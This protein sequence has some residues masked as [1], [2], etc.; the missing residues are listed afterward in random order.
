MAAEDKPRLELARSVLP[1]PLLAAL[2]HI[3]AQNLSGCMLVGGTALAGF[4]AG[5]RRSDD[6]DLFTDGSDSQ[7]AVVLAVES[8]RDL[9][10]EL[11][12]QQRS[13]QF[14][15][16][17]CRFRGAVFT[18]DAARHQSLFK[19][20]AAVRLENGITV[21]SLRTLL[22]MKAA[23]LLSRCGEKDLYDL[24]WIFGRFRDLRLEDMVSAGAGVDAGSTP[25]GLLIALAGARPEEKSC[26]FALDPKI[27]ARQVYDDVVRLRKELIRGLKRLAE[28][29]PA[30][31]LSELI[32]KVRRLE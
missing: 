23:A 4:Y 28:A 27:G 7:E 25:E 3:F 20:G 24:I 2:E 17:V 29:E 11:E 32:N 19:T 15:R 6:L 31:A 14:Y 18:V 13:A 22:A 8:L 30:P 21:A 16:A 5:H 10:A 9:G 1:E 26:G 12:V